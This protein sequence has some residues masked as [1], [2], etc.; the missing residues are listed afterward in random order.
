MARTVSWKLFLTPSLLF[1]C[2][3]VPL[4][5]CG[6]SGNGS[7]ITLTTAPPV[8]VNLTVTGAAPIVAASQVNGGSWSTLSLAGSKATFTVP[9]P[10]SNYAVA[11][12][13]P[14]SAAFPPNQVQAIFEASASDTTS[15]AVYCPP[16][17]LLTVTFNF[18][19]SAIPSAQQAAIA[20]GTDLSPYLPGPTSSASLQN[21]AAG[22]E[23]IGV[24]AYGTTANTPPLGLQIQRGVNITGS[25]ITIPPMNTSDQTGSESI[26]VTNIPS[27]YTNYV[28]ASYVTAGGTTIPINGMQ[29]PTSYAT[30]ASGDSAQGDFYSVQSTSLNGGAGVEVVQSFTMPQNLTLNLPGVLSY[31]GPSPAPYP[32]FSAAYN[33]FTGSGMTGW[34]AS[35]SWVSSASEIEVV[36]YA[37]NTFLGSSS[38]TIPNLSSVN[39]FV[40]APPTNTL[41]GWALI[42]FQQSAPYFVFRVTASPP[43]EAAQYAYVGGSY[44]EP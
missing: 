10:T 28:I 37:T 42:A 13:C 3:I 22:T 40:Q 34:I 6:G 16:T 19:L 31:G 1:M 11:V 12:L 27:G 4:M 20:V 29:V 5:A 43:N 24:A 25:P 36:V 33:G 9:G 35:N 38:I 23:D 14:I 17:S 39:G 30:I 44:I 8:Q 26:A 2:A 15:P 21:V 7:T 18:N 41:V 32:T